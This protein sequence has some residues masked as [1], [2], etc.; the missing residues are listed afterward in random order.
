MAVDAPSDFSVTGEA[1]PEKAPPPDSVPNIG[2]ENLLK[3]PSSWEGSEQKRQ[4]L[5]AGQ[6]RARFA[7]LAKEQQAVEE[8]LGKARRELDGMAGQGGGGPWQMGAPGSN[9][10]EVTPM[11]F[12]HRELIRS[13]KEQLEAL[14]RRERALS[15]EA[16][17]AGVPE[18]WRIFDSPPER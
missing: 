1:L 5:S 3:L 10:T 2:L 8:M 18:A 7:G 16:D 12:K 4:G 14:R 17:I 9:N 6:W 13:G 15:I 11:S